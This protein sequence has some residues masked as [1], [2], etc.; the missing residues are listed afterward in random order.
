M[1]YEPKKNEKIEGKLGIIINTIKS[2][3]SSLPR[4]VFRGK[5]RVVLFYSHFCILEIVSLLNTN[6]EIINTKSF[7]VKPMEPSSKLTEVQKC[8]CLLV[9]PPTST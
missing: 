9:A 3:A 6:T 4:H 1:V 8:R 5:S 7:V 2:M